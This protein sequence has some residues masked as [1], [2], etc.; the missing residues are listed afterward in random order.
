MMAEITKDNSQSAS[1]VSLCNDYEHYLRCIA[2]FDKGVSGWLADYKIWVKD[3]LG[4]RILEKLDV[5][6]P[7]GGQLRIL[8]VGSGEGEVECNLISRV[9]TTYRSIHNTVVDPSVTQLDL[10][11]AR[12]KDIQQQSALR[13]VDFDWH[14][15]TLAQ[16]RLSSEQ[17][18]D[19]TKFHLIS[20]LFCL[21]YEPDMDSMLDYLYSRLE[22]GGVLLV[23]LESEKCDVIKIEERFRF[24]QDDLNPLFSSRDLRDYFSGHSIPHAVCG[25]LNEHHDFDITAAFDDSSEEGALLLDFLSNVLNFRESVSSSVLEEFKA[26][27]R[28][29]ATGRDG[30]EFLYYDSEHIIA[31]KP[32][33]ATSRKEL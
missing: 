11:N 19:Q 8:G 27:L 12:V 5:A 24:A 23:A 26:Y 20:A 29:L 2:Q 13:G 16:Y 9:L 10:Y 18:G 32:R 28:S 22:P 1:L 31:W 7:K 33:M 17:S 14:A 15:E 4:T 3:D 6:V 21:Y 30:K 25:Q